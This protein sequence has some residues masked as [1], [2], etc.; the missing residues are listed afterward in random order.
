MKLQCGLICGLGGFL[1]QQ[2]YGFGLKTSGR[3]RSSAE[4]FLIQNADYAG[5]ASY[6]RWPGVVHL[7]NG[8]SP[9]GCSGV[10]VRS[11]VILTAGSCISGDR[12]EQSGTQVSVQD[13]NAITVWMGAGWDEDA[14]GPAPVSGQL[15]RI[16]SISN[17]SYVFVPGFHGSNLAVGV[18][19]FD[20][21]SGT[22]LVIPHGFIFEATGGDV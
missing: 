16:G 20:D 5:M 3:G 1:A 13:T 7:E 15:S 18:V 19:D 21:P 11:N 10:F 12:T 9:F 6:E 4:R 14:N 17:A 8:R 2:A 22:T